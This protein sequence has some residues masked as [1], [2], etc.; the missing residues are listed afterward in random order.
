[1]TM[2]RYIARR[3][4]A[5]VGTIL[6][7]TAIANVLF[8]T[9]IDQ[10]SFGA[11]VRAV[12]AY[13]GDT[14]LRGEFGTTGGG[15][16]GAQSEGVFLLCSTY[17]RGPVG[18]MLRERGMVDLQL[19]VGGLLLGTLLGLWA[20]RYT[21]AHPG[22]RRTRLIHGATAVLMSCPPY[23]LAFVV[24]WYF[25]WNSGEFALP[26]VSGQ[27]DYV[28]FSEDPLGWTK[29]IWAPWV[30]VALPPAAFVARM[31]EASMRD[32]L[33]S[34]FIRTAR[35]KGLADKRVLNLHAL[36]AAAPPI[37]ALTGVNVSTMLINAAAIEYGFSLP[38][39]FTTIRGAINVSD[40]AVLQAIVLEGVILVVIANFVA[41]AVIARLDPRVWA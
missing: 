19:L 30:L 2:H 13:L 39:M 23:F 36:P 17:G 32:V 21:S 4:G 33:D 28:P 7:A 34:D 18:D 8:A 24:L 16:C 37:A 22:T 6:L 27:G 12:P 5:L 10:L 31:T 15:G 41:D 3:L 38:G 1:M 20:G 35:A 29:A 9:S 14:F 26:F 11:A 40:V 25:A